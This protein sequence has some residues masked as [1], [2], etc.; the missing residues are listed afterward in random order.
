MTTNQQMQRFLGGVEQNYEPVTT[1]TGP[2]TAA[3]YD[4]VT[5]IDT[6][7][8]AIGAITL[9]NT[10]PVGTAREHTFLDI[11]G[12]ANTNP[13]TINAPGGG[14]INGAASI[15][16][17]VPY[18]GV[19]LFTDDGVNY[20]TP[21]TPLVA[22]ATIVL[23]F[24]GAITPAGTNNTYT[25]DATGTSVAVVNLR[26]TIPVKWKLLEARMF[27]YVNTL[28]NASVVTVRKNNV[29]VATLNVPAGTTGLY[30]ASV[31][32]DFDGTAGVD[33]Y[34]DVFET[35]TG[36]GAGT[37]RMSL[38]CYGTTAGATGLLN[39]PDFIFKPGVA[40]NPA[41]NQYN[42]FVNLMAAVV[43]YSAG[44]FP[45]TI[46]VDLSVAGTPYTMPAGVFAFGSEA[47]VRGSDSMPT[48]SPQTLQW[49]GSITT[50][51]GIA[52]ISGNLLFDSIDAGGA[53]PWSFSGGTGQFVLRLTR[54]A[55]LV[56]TLAPLIDLAV[57]DFL[58]FIL[59][60][61]SQ[62]ANNGS[63]VVKMNAGNSVVQVD[64]L[65]SSVFGQDVVTAAGVAN[66]LNLYK[67]TVPAHL[68]DVHAAFAGTTT[69]TAVFFLPLA[70]FA[71]ETLPLAAGAYFLQ[72]ATNPAVAAADRPYL[73]AAPVGF[74]GPVL[75]Q[76]HLWAAANGTAGA[77]AVT[78]DILVNGVV[79][80]TVGINVAALVAGYTLA[81]NGPPLNAT[82]TLSV[83]ITIGV[84]G[85]AATPTGLHCR[86]FAA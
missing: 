14:T 33:D 38:I 62:I 76:A 45:Y 65:D 19:V 39:E 84:G 53:I 64:G 7:T 8:G 74:P 51:T 30:A 46:Y 3:I 75:L 72:F 69:Y 35:V 79:K 12:M 20:I 17:N 37:M 11:G 56:P 73:Q 36:A 16:I 86:V 26:Y 83:S 31:N 55:Q 10:V 68:S 54:G 25:A 13:V 52:E 22:A 63:A 48:A 2:Y 44:N 66:A 28:A 67:S 9:P 82:D 57:G 41:I 58:N 1:A 50:F 78:L 6:S 21:T 47:V 27:V 23:P 77:G 15:T 40:S 60:D 70:D 32:V 85:I 49:D 29:A 34:I 80:A 5:L 81:M 4:A 43:P 24:A 42:D 59:R 61:N 18:G 71:A